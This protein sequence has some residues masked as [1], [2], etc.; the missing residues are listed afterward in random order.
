MSL[1]LAEMSTRMGKWIASLVDGLDKHVDAE[2]IAKILEQC[3]R[4]CQSPNFVKK[5]KDLYKK[6]KNVNDFYERLAVKQSE[7]A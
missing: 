6:S 4:R 5:T 1:G 7:A 3:G 2:T